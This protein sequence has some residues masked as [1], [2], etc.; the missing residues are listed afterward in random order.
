MELGHGDNLFIRRSLLDLGPLPRADLFKG[1]GVVWVAVR[2]ESVEGGGGGGEGRE[3]GSMVEEGREER[4][5][6]GRGGKGRVGKN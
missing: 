1:H 6:E 5:G 2:R 4:G 3:G